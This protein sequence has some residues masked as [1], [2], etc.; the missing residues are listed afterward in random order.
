M[1]EK[2]F[3]EK[4]LTH[5]LEEQ[6]WFYNQR[7][8]QAGGERSSL[9]LKRVQFFRANL[10]HLRKRLGRLL[11]IVDLG[12]GRGLYA[13]LAADFGHV[14][15]VDLSSTGIE[16]AKKN[17]P[18]PT[19]HVGNVFDFHTDV[20]K[21]VV[22]SSEVIEHVEDQ[23]GYIFKC[24]QLLADNGILLL[25]MPNRRAARWYWKV[26]SHKHIAQPLEKWLS[27]R[28]I[29]KLLLPYFR[30]EYLASCDP[31]YSR[32]GIMHVINSVKLNYVFSL[33]GFEGILGRWW[34]R[35]GFGLYLFIRAR[36][37]LGTQSLNRY[38]FDSYSR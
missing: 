3:A 30:V 11:R 36:K 13:S 37:H 22:I 1:R 21:D 35:I 25:T 15:A 4:S 24:Y 29:H 6:A 16:S 2:D 31:A 10:E 18:G 28:Q 20:P 14:E 9:E 12:C 33:I 26:S 17:F 23:A 8:A 34:E 38:G 7:W 5:T 32:I 19:Y 27:P